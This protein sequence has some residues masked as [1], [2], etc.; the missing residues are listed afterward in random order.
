ME[1]KNMHY[2][3]VSVYTSVSGWAENSLAS[4]LTLHQESRTAKHRASFVNG[5]LCAYKYQVRPALVSEQKAV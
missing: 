5:W 2:I 1:M 4:D 3:Q